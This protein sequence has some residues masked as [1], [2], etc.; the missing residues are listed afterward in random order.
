MN[1]IR[2]VPGDG[3]NFDG[4]TTPGVGASW[5]GWLNEHSESFDIGVANLKAKLEEAL[6]ALQANPSQP[7]YLAAYQTALSEY[8][9]YRMLQSSSAKALSDMAKGNARNLG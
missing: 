4:G 8:N 9:L 1:N 7:K 5:E 2:L 3:T 6:T